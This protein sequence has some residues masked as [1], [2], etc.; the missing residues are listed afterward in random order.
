MAPRL[1]RL[2]LDPFER[3]AF[4]SRVFSLNIL[5][6][7]LNQNSVIGRA[8]H[9]RDPEGQTFGLAPQGQGTGL[10]GKFD[11]V[12]TRDLGLDLHIS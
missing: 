5:H 3:Q 12:A 6:G 2:F 9:G 4:Q 11:I 7:K 8:S 10:Q 1:G